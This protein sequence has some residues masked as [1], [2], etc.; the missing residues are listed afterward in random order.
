MYVHV[1]CMHAMYV[2]VTVY[3]I[4]PHRV[5]SEGPEKL[6]NDNSI[7]LAGKHAMAHAT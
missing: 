6:N 7:F 1:L 5:S 3:V 2:S 4:Q